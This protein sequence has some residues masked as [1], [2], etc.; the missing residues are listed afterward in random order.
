ME[1]EPN[2]RNETIR[3]TRDNRKLSLK[4]L[5]LGISFVVLSFV[6]IILTILS[7]SDNQPGE[8]H[9]FLY[10]MLFKIFWVIF[11]TGAALIIYSMVAL[12][13]GAKPDI[14]KLFPS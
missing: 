2:S 5:I 11:I 12:F 10:K 3:N 14:D 7:V 13:L 9:S 4:I 1:N 6:I 8:S